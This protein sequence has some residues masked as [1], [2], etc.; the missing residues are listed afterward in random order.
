MMNTRTDKP[1]ELRIFISS[2]FK[3]FL[4]ER[5]RLF[6]HVFP[7]VRQAARRRGVEFTAIDLRWG[8][9]D[10]QAQLGHAISSCLME[11]DECHPYFIGLIG[12]RYGW[13]P[14]S[15]E[16]DPSTGWISNPSTP[17]LSNR[18]SEWIAVGKSVTAMEILHGVLAR[19]DNGVADAHFYLRH[20]DLTDE[21]AKA[22]TNPDDF[23]DAENVSRQTEF[24]QEIQDMDG[25]QGVHVRGY[26]T[27]E[28][29]I[30]KTE[31]DL[32]ELLDRGW[33][34]QENL[35]ALEIERRAHQAY[36]R[37][38]LSSY[39][40]NIDALNSIFQTMQDSQRV[41]LEGPSG[42]GKSS[43]MA[44]L[45]K[46]FQDNFDDCFV[47]Q[48]FPGIA[49]GASPGIVLE[50]VVAEICERLGL[51]ADKISTETAL[52]NEFHT[53][54][55]E[56][57][58]R[59]IP[60]L[61][62]LDALNQLGEIS[63]SARWLQSELPEGI[64]MLAAT[65]P[66]HIGAWLAE[67]GWVIQT[68]PELNADQIRK[69]IVGEGNSRGYL[70]KFTK[71]LTEPQ[72]KRIAE[73]EPSRSP[74]YLRVLL[75]ELIAHG[76]LNKDRQTQNE[77]MDSVLESY[78][79]C[80]D[81]ATLYQK[82]L[83]RLESAFSSQVVGDVLGLIACSREGLSEDELARIKNHAQVDIVL[84]RQALDFHLM[85]RDGL[86]ILSHQ[87][88]LQAVTSRY[89]EEPLRTAI[90]DFFL[91]EASQ[92]TSG[93]RNYRKFTELPWQL[94]RLGRFDDLATFLTTPDNIRV[95]SNRYDIGVR[96]LVVV[97]FM[98]DMV[99]YW[100][101]LRR[102][103]FQAREQ[104]A[105]LIK[106]ERDRTEKEFGDRHRV[107][108]PDKQF[109]L[110]DV[111]TGQL[112]YE[113][114]R[115]L[116]AIGE[117]PLDGLPDSK[118]KIDPIDEQLEKVREAF[119]TATTAARLRQELKVVVGKSGAAPSDLLETLM[120]T[121]L[122]LKAKQPFLQSFIQEIEPGAYETDKVFGPTILGVVNWQPLAEAYFA[123][124]DVEK[125]LEIFKDKLIPRLK[126]DR[127]HEEQLAE[128]QCKYS[129]ALFAV[130]SVEESYMQGA[131]ALRWYDQHFPAGSDETMRVLKSLTVATL[132]I[133]D[134]QRRLGKQVEL[135]EFRDKHSQEPHD[136]IDTIKLC[137]LA[138]L[139]DGNGMHASSEQ[140]EAIGR[141]CAKATR[142]C[143]GLF[144]DRGLDDWVRLSAQYSLPV[145]RVC[146]GPESSRTLAIEQIA[147]S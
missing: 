53:L 97:S 140:L 55:S 90:I 44:W 29:F 81:V 11:V 104:F 114:N 2:T 100:K 111:M 86:W 83:A 106:E 73:H 68:L 109:D 143:L 64:C 121:E 33:P 70:A 123:V 126:L 130:G 95:M 79:A 119:D 138:I 103:G 110:V 28:I 1:R 4:W 9:T 117:L 122:S 6:S 145:Y 85:N 52:I 8:I 82:V 118:N 112:A 76:G 120:G 56:L 59:R 115:I 18:I 61:I 87:A 107:Q 99:T 38:R 142:I 89:P 16:Q 133:T 72:L 80:P 94:M 57:S 40:P 136:Y 23:Y 147:N 131:S 71:S 54:L 51:K 3:D 129:E 58:K 15:V 39:A 127:E 10:E 84:L 36:A 19:P 60:T 134:A 17:E 25:R 22:S 146:F 24:R 144:K 128:V 96:G 20:R 43:A 34:E 13:I 98:A 102:R 92:D 47:L 63:Q 125:S 137:A 62:A 41:L 42:S 21:F 77:Y 12:E 27:R 75:E 132:E 45:A 46:H 66:G 113:L 65:Q 37:D 135:L 93:A 49:P 108:A 69:V 32:M 124:G 91:P 105:R 35:P 30:K 74:L 88:M 48:H 50:R 26:R 5:D 116:S 141:T 67:Q 14:K 31:K 101:E 7:T 78:L 139:G